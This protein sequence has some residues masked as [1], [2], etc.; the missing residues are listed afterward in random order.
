MSKLSV[1]EIKEKINIIEKEGESNLYFLETELEF[2]RED[3]AKTYSRI[4]YLSTE[5]DMF[6]DKVVSWEGPVWEG[7]ATYIPFKENGEFAEYGEIKLSGYLLESPMIFRVE[8]Y[9]FCL[10]GKFNPPQI[11][12]ITEA[13]PCEGCWHL[14]YLNE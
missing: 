14:S 7:P 5:S 12:H 8:D 4:I 1:E 2:T 3:G 9:L 6:A 10:C 11:H 13:S